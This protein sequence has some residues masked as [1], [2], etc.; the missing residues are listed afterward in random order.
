MLT[1][2]IAGGSGAGKT[3]LAEK[4]VEHFGPDRAIIVSQDSYYRDHSHLPPE[5]RQEGNFDEPRAVK[6][7]LLVKQLDQLRSGQPVEKPR[8][9]YATHTRI[10]SDTVSP[11]DIVIVDGL[12]VL[13]DDDVRSRMDLKVFVGAPEEVRVQ[14]RV[15]RDRRERGRT[16]DEIVERLN[17]TVLPMHAIHVEPYRELADIIVDGC[18]NA[19]AEAARV[20]AAIEAQMGR[21]VG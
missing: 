11:H 7:S 12:F 16:E 4:L 9:D 10:G 19:D 1:I 6:L 3:V 17:A 20:I 2:G 13:T 14:R 21:R 5:K 8:Y 18:G 15:D